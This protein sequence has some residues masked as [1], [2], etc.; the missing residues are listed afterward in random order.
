[1]FAIKAKMTPYGL[2]WSCWKRGHRLSN[3]CMLSMISVLFLSG[4][5]KSSKSSRP[6]KSDSDDSQTPTTSTTRQVHTLRVTLDGKRSFRV[7]VSGLPENQSYQP[8]VCW[9]YTRMKLSGKRYK[10]IP[11]PVLGTVEF[12]EGT[13]S[14]IELTKSREGFNVEPTGSNLVLFSAAKY[15]EKGGVLE[16]FMKKIDGRQGEYVLESQYALEVESGSIP[17][18]SGV[19]LTPKHFYLIYPWPYDYKSMLSPRREGGSVPFHTE[20]TQQS[21]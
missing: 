17:K 1:M 14:G 5:N 2:M 3:V 21:K 11:F 20:I 9:G 7:I 4:C 8:V 15:P 12:K 10:S 18:I 13:F 19:E 6:V 16:C